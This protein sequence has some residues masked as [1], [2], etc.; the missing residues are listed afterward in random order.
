MGELSSKNVYV[1][2]KDAKH[3]NRLFEIS[4]LHK[5]SYLRDV[6]DDTSDYF[7]YLL[8]YSCKAFSNWF[9]VDVYKYT[10]VT[11]EEFEQILKQENNVRSSI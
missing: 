4:E 2:I 8:G 9:S 1:K 7:Y 10:E 3:L 5:I 11:T 6:H